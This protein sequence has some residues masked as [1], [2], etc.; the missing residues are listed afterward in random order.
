MKKILSFI[1]ICCLPLNVTAHP[2]TTSVTLNQSWWTRLTRTC[3]NTLRV[4]PAMFT[5]ALQK[6]KSAPWANI[7]I[8][9]AALAVTTAACYGLFT[10]VRKLSGTSKK[11]KKIPN[12]PA[13][14]TPPKQH[15]GSKNNQITNTDTEHLPQLVTDSAPDLLHRLP[16]IAYLTD[17]THHKDDPINTPNVTEVSKIP[18]GTPRIK[19]QQLEV[20]NQ[21][22][23]N[24]GDAR[25]ALHSIKNLA[26]IYRLILGHAIAPNFL[27]DATLAED[28]INPLAKTIDIDD[29]KENLKAYYKTKIEILEATAID[30]D[31]GT[32]SV[33][34]AYYERLINE[35]IA[36][37]ANDVVDNNISRTINHDELI[38]ELQSCRLP[39]GASTQEQPFFDYIKQPANIDRFIKF[40]DGNSLTISSTDLKLSS[41]VKYYKEKFNVSEP[42]SPLEG[43]IDTR[44]GLLNC[45][46]SLFNRYIE[47][48]ARE[49][50]AQE[51]NSSY[52]RTITRANMLQDIQSLELGVT[53][54]Q[55]QNMGKTY[56]K[57]ALERFIRNGATINRFIKIRDGDKFVISSLHAKT[58]NT[59]NGGNGNWFDKERMQRILRQ[60]IEKKT[61]IG[62]LW[63][64]PEKNNINVNKPI[65][66]DVVQYHQ[67]DQLQPE[68]T[69]IRQNIAAGNLPDG[70]Y[71]F[72]VGTMQGNSRGHW[73]ALALESSGNERRY[74]IADS[75][76]HYQLHG[77]ACA[78]LINYFEGKQENEYL[79][80]LIAHINSMI[81]ECENAQKMGAVPQTLKDK[82]QDAIQ[83]YDLENG[84]YSPWGNVADFTSRTQP[85]L[86]KN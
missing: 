42:D 5:H 61:L 71:G 28:L 84:D 7:A 40:A 31:I 36:C 41:I 17:L 21:F 34:R 68:L 11:G 20:T 49:V 69:N 1:L 22:K 60:A 44:Q 82:L 9:G 43:D 48:L 63:Q 77:G 74:T 23:N 58:S 15:A 55:L 80:S 24:L 53:D 32:P 72:I 4:I 8:T 12:P 59:L 14:I 85:L 79:P 62:E 16:K 46:K 29:Q 50:I 35:C 78:K 76:G 19:K 45:Y 25:C 2:L 26:G 33:L 6:I 65:I 56:N 30:G 38:Y 70:L 64:P 18:N 66:V 83:T 39:E 67:F 57:E 37:L 52:T 13:R 86:K 27:T 3:T 75:A 81:I 10:L 47:N 54:L 51:N 73:T